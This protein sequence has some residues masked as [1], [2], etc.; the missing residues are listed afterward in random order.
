MDPLTT[1]LLSDPRTLGAYNDHD[2]DYRFTFSIQ[3]K[4]IIFLITS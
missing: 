4:V 3:T 1:L 2:L